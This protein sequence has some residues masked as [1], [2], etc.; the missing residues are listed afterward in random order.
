M[1]YVEHMG[2]NTVNSLFLILAAALSL[3][4]CKSS[5]NPLAYQQDPV[6]IYLNEQ[7][8]GASGGVAATEKQVESTHSDYLKALESQTAIQIKRSHYYRAVDR[9]RHQ[10]QHL[11]WLRYRLMREEKLAQERYLRQNLAQAD[12]KQD[13]NAWKGHDRMKLLSES[14]RGFSAAS[15]PQTQ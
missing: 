10:Q 6:V 9:L 12:E 15:A 5:I 14:R 11:T 3:S 8:Q 4:S 7:I 1:F 2:K 13:P